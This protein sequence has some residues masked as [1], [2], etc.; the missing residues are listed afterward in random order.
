MRDV[1]VLRMNK[2]TAVHRGRVAVIIV[3][4]RGG[5]KHITHGVRAKTLCTS[6]QFLVLRGPSSAPGAASRPETFIKDVHW[7]LLLQTRARV[8]CTYKEAADHL[9]TSFRCALAILPTTVSQAR[10]LPLPCSW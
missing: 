4:K 1:T 8:C 2:A 5:N 6:P 3:A 7:A 9:G 10:R